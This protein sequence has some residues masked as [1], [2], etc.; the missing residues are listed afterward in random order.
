ME[1]L[2]RNENG[3]GN[4]DDFLKDEETFLYEKPLSNIYNKRAQIYCRMY[5][6]AVYRLKVLN[7]LKKMKKYDPKFM[8]FLKNP[9]TTEES[10]NESSSEESFLI[11]G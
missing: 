10:Q 9:K 4:F 1:T 2:K 3:I 5:S 8:D 6:K 7:E 11:N